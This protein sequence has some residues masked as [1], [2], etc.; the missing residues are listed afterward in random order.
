[1][2]CWGFQAK[3]VQEEICNLQAP[4]Q[5]ELQA[6]VKKFAHDV[7]DFD[8]DFEMNG[9]MIPGLSASE[10]SDR[11][12]LFQG[13]FDDL[14]DSFQTFS[15]GEKLFG[16]EITDYPVLHQK[17]RELNLLQK[18]YGLYVAVNKSIDGYFDLLWTD[19]EIDQII[20]EITEF[21]NRY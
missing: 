3:I 10:A 6:G 1:M 18:L 14:W 13:R 19:V 7:D 5:I 9:P 2:I 21:Q 16:M 12:L 8:R 17:K 20:E 15:S 4:F 11:V